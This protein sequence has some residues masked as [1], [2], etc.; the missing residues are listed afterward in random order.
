MAQLIDNYFELATQIGRRWFVSKP[1]K[2]PFI[3]RLRDVWGV[4]TGRYDAVKFAEIENVKDK[5]WHKKTKVLSA[6][7]VERAKEAAHLK[8]QKKVFKG[9]VSSFGKLTTKRN[10]PC[11]CG[12]GRKFKNC[13]GKQQE[14]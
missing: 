4:L 10:H 9:D 6:L 11:P 12:S 14:N 7:D 1:V 5:N 13:C 2:G 3:T 8:L